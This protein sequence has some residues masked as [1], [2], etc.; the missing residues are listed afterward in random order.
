MP[1]RQRSRLRHAGRPRPLGP[2][3][4]ADRAP[5]R[6]AEGADL[7]TFSGDKLLGG[8]QAGFIVGRRR[9]RRAHQPQP[10]EARAAPRQDPARRPRGDAAPL[11]R[12]R[13]AGRAAADPASARRAR[14]RRSPRWPTPARRCLPTP[15]GAA[16]AV[17]VT[18]CASQIGSGALPLETM[19]S[20][21]LALRPADPQAR[22]QAV[23]E[24]SPPPS[25]RLPV[26]VIGRIADGALILDLRCLE[27]GTPSA[28]TSP[29]STLA[30]TLARP[31]RPPSGARRPAMT[32]PTPPRRGRRLRDRAGDLGAA[33]ARRRCRGPRTTSA[34]ASPTASASPRTPASR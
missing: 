12:S 6:S 23:L 31:P 14:S 7:V 9:S 28:A 8:P 34:P 24:A 29:P 25:A 5:R 15:L 22:G 10:D 17:D 2:A 1:L 30:M 21:G 3:A 27:D 19:P 32:A 18:D 11:P 33:G 4:R 13:P 16:F 26:P 20:A